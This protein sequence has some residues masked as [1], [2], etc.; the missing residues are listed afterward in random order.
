M[1]RLWSVGVILINAFL[2][3][4]QW[5]IIGTRAMGMGG[6]Y[7]AMAKGPIAQYWNPAGLYQPSAQNFSGVELNAGVGIE[8]TGGILDHVSEITQVSKQIKDIQNSQT[9]T[10]TIIDSNQFSAFVKTLGILNE[11]TKKDDLG[12]LVEANGSFG[13]KFSKL[14]LSLNNYTSVGVNPWIDVQNINL[15]NTSNPG[16][17][18]PKETDLTDYSNYQDEADRLADLITYIAGTNSRTSSLQGTNLEGLLCG[19]DSSNNPRNCLSQNNI[20]TAQDFAYALVRQLAENGVPESEI[21]RFL[22]EA[23]RYVPQARDLISA[24]ASGSGSFENNQSYL[25]LKARSFTELAI[26]YAWD[27]SRLLS[28]LSVGTNLKLIR[29]DIA[30]KTFYFV[31]EDETSKAFDDILEK[32][33]TSTK[34]SIDIGLLWNVDEYLRIPY[35]PR[36]G[37]VVRNLNGP[38]FDDF[39]KSYKLSPQA[40]FGVAISPL[41]WWH[42]SFDMDLTKNSTPVDGFYSKQISFGTEIN[43]INRKSFNLPI[44]LGALKNIA[45]DDSKTMYTAGIGLTFAYIHLDAAVGISSGKSRIDDKEYPQKAQAVVNVGILF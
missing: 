9:S 30:E 45:E 5:Q 42:L 12:A 35:S 7:V 28:G 25:N 1:R 22:D 10:T 13:L 37:V 33:K 29:A 31:G 26:G 8:A 4:E 15:V 27:M 19:F 16:I 39:N 20:Y 40:R 17:N 11:M 38:R 21:M 3:G 32:R 18:L 6:A 23:E 24:L 14:T 34:P 2:Y 43:L 44:R 36:V 41:K